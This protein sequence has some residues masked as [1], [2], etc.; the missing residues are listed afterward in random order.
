MGD[1][2]PI[3]SLNPRD[4][5]KY[6][7][8][9]ASL[10]LRAFLEAIRRK[11]PDWLGLAVAQ[12]SCDD[13]IKRILCNRDDDAPRKD[14]SDLAVQVHWGDEVSRATTDRMGFHC[15]APNS[16]LHMGFAARGKRALLANVAA[17]RGGSS[18]VKTECHWQ[19]DGSVYI[20]SPFAF[21]HAVEYPK[22]VF[23]D[24]IVAIQCR[25][26][27]SQKEAKQLAA[28]SGWEDVL[29]RLSQ[30]LLLSPPRMPSLKEVLAVENEMWRQG[31]L[32]RASRL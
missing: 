17:D 2:L 1:A 3:E 14:F 15:D 26:E 11:N 21:M 4:H 13:C 27:M 25:I 7:K 8:P 18:N 28:T 32:R 19:R 29:Y 16:L 23:R 6:L 12:S 31:G 5:S 10:P 9:A 24:R 22:C 30:L 20:S